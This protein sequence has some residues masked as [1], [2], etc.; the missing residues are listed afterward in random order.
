[1]EINRRYKYIRYQNKDI[2]SV[3][4][5]ELIQAFACSHRYSNFQ[6][7][8][9]IKDMKAWPE[10]SRFYVWLSHKFM[11]YNVASSTSI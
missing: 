4:D 7:L 5:K 1:M 2:R 9:S 11:D 10:Q 3:S 6:I 8:S